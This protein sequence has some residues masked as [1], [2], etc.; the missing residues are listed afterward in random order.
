MRP[1]RNPRRGRQRVFR[2]MPAKSRAFFRF[3]DAEVDSF[4]DVTVCPLSAYRGQPLKPLTLLGIY[5]VKSRHIYLD[6]MHDA[7][8]FF[9]EA[10]HHIITLHMPHLYK[11]ARGRAV[12]EAVADIA[13]AI[14]AM[15][16]ETPRGTGWRLIQ[17]GLALK[18]CRRL[19]FDEDGDPHLSVR[20]ILLAIKAK[21]R[22]ITRLF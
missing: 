9:H 6:D 21:P 14:S 3:W 5:V 2:N 17:M 11:T 15:R 13:A 18:H 20:C 1:R 19:R 4:A 12:E 10:S 8:T 7:K 16:L 22:L